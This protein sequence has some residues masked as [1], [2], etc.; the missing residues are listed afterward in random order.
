MFAEDFNPTAA[1]VAT[2]CPR[3]AHAGLVEVTHEQYILAPRNHRHDSKAVIC[4]NL[5]ARCPKCGVVA[6]WPDCLES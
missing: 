2:S 6:E 3:C 4:P 1:L 5:Y